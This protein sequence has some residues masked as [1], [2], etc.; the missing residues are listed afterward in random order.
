MKGSDAVKYGLATALKYEDEVKDEI[1]TKLG[2]KKSDELKT[3]SYDKY[4]EIVL[5]KKPSSNDNKIAV[6]YAEGEINDGKS[7]DGVI[8]GEAFVKI[9]QQIENDESVKGV[10]LRVNSPGGSAFASEQI[11]HALKKLKLNL[12]NQQVNHSTLILFTQRLSALLQTI[13]RAVIF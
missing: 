9:I 5:A 6:I 4:K 1:K 12:I 8:G 10:V 13:I 7:D 11:H 3:I 2:Y